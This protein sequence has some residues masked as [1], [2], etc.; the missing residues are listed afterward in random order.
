MERPDWAPDGIDTE[1][2]SAARIYDYALGGVHNFSVDREA[3]RVMF[4]VMPDLPLSMQANRAFLRRAVQ[5]LAERGI[6]QLLDVGSGIP[7][8]GNVHEVAQRIDPETRVMYVDIDPVAV[9]HSRA[10]L[11]GN[12]R[13]NVIQADIRQP[14][15]ILSDPDVRGLLDFDQPIGLLLVSVLQFV[16]EAD[17]P[18]GIVAR[19]RDALAPGSYVVISQPTNDAM[20]KEGEEVEQMIHERVPGNF[21][22][23]TRESFER[24]FA[25]FQVERPGIV[26]GPL[27]YPDTPSYVEENPEHSMIYVGVGRKV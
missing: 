19:F 17:D 5:F 10:V 8:V 21:Q 16:P 24:L 4:E 7:T 14:D 26:W 15:A 2:P 11:T 12:D 20:R 23:A 3:A 27:W 1:R 9:A 22:Y 25:G 13:A 6:R 18:P